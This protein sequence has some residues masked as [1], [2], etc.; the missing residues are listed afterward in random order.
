MRRVLY[1]SRDTRKQAEKGDNLKEKFLRFPLF[2]AVITMTAVL[3]LT[4][5]ETKKKKSVATEAPAASV[6]VIS[7]ADFKGVVR[8]IDKASGK[9]SIYETI[10]GTTEEYAYSGATEILS[11]NNRDM[12]M[13]EVEIGEVYDIYT[14]DNGKK[15]EKM[16]K[17]SDIIEQENKKISVD[18]E[19][20]RITVD[21]VH[22]AYTDDVI[23][24]SDGKY[25]TPMEITG[26]DRVTFRGVRGQVYSLVVTRGH[27]YI[28]PT[29]Y[30]ELAG[31]TLIIDGES[32]LDISD[33]MLLTVPEGTQ[34]LT[35]ANRT[36]TATATAE[37]ERGQV[38]TLDM[39]R[40]IEN[41][42]DIARVEFKIEPAGAEL[43]IDGVETT[44]KKAVLLRYGTHTVQVVLEGYTDYIGTLTVREPNPT[45]SISLSKETA[46]ISSDE[47]SSTKS[48]DSSEAPSSTSS[49]SGTSDAEYDTEH[50][51]TVS[52]PKGAAVYINGTYK[53]EAP[54][55]FTKMLGDVT[56]TLSKD[57]YETKSYEI[58][59]SDD[60]QDITWS[61]PDL[62]KDGDG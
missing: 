50:Q 36:Y 21:N 53:G 28:K 31:G 26:N 32:I 57:G 45:V 1:N 47:D 41:R 40:Y 52:T 55:S 15:L 42:K 4:G 48:S 11:K 51:I 14:T 34:K 13:D 39:S 17:S 22:Y 43:Y 2:F 7:G 59:I 46:E 38:V 16:Q 60:S 44:Y 49:S 27:G 58:K 6:T 9:I 8:S 5:C 19:N 54:C 56:I 12:S 33:N 61:F 20:K 25:I 29:N 24:Y 3:G 18:T 37:V 30:E 35:M 62:E 10:F 23:V